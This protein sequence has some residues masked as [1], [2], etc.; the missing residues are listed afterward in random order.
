R[1]WEL[2][3]SRLLREHRPSQ[4]KKDPIWTVTNTVQAL[5]FAPNGG[6]LACGCLDNNVYLIDP[7]TGEVKSRLVGHRLGNGSESVSPAEPSS[8]RF[9]VSSLAYS[10]DG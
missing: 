7:R 2:P 3:A 9:G 5:A 6:T 1:Y 4:W 10:P 8:S